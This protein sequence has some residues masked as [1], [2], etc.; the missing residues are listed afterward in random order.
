MFTILS[1][2]FKFSIAVETDTNSKGNG[3]FGFLET[4]N[5]EVEGKQNSPFPTGP[6][7]C[8][9]SQLKIGKK[10]RKNRLLDAGWLTGHRL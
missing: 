3:E 4:H 6:V 7:F 5:V 1:F 10:Q 8:Y 9:T 2:H